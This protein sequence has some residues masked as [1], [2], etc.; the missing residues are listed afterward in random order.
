MKRILVCKRKF[1]NQALILC[2]LYRIKLIDNFKEKLHSDLYKKVNFFEH[3]HKMKINN[4][5]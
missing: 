4:N 5:N 3:N 1:F 2:D